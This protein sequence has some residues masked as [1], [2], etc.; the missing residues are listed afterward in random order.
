MIILQEIAIVIILVFLLR[1]YCIY[2]Q[3]GRRCWKGMLRFYQADW[4]LLFY[5]TFEFQALYSS[6]RLFIIYVRNL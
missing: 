3:F 6:I 2:I 1:I 4:S 5:Q